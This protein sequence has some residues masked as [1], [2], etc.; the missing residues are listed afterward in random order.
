M[1]PQRGEATTD[2]GLANDN[3]SHYSFDIAR[4]VSA[5]APTSPQPPS[6][7]IVCICHRVSDRDFARHAAAGVSHTVHAARRVPMPA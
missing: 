2:H 1:T 6:T 4:A 7:M 3:D 5:I